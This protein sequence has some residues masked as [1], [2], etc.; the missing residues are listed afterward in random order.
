VVSVVVP[1]QAATN[2]AITRRITHS[3]LALTLLRSFISPPEFSPQRVLGPTPDALQSFV[4][5]LT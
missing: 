4:G 1:V 3:G 5:H 2:I